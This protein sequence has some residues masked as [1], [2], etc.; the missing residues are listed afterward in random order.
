MPR[1]RILASCVAL[2]AS[3]VLLSACGGGGGGG[4]GGTA[5][6]AG[7]S[8]GGGAAASG[9]NPGN[10]GSGTTLTVPQEPDSGVDSPTG[11]CW[12]AI[13]PTPVG[14]PAI[15]TAPSGA[16]TT[17]KLAW[18]AK[19]LYILAWTQQWP[20]DAKNC[21]SNWWQCDTTE[22]TVSGADDHAGAY[23][24]SSN[25]FQFGIVNDGSLKTGNNGSNAP[26]SLVKAQTKIVQNKGFY[27]ELFVPWQAIGVSAPKKGQKFQFDIAEDY[28]DGQ[29]NRT[30]QYV[31]AGDQEFW[32]D[33]SKWGDITLG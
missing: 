21:G 32:H 19:G 5:G 2:L 25:T 20:L 18:S 17:F 16:S 14:I 15:G 11:K 29:G 4:G 3:G 24:G 30:A 33:D 9:C 7:G 8:G 10:A 23:D 6:N 22:I 28:G 12:D 27:S 13:K 31:W 1:S 26:T